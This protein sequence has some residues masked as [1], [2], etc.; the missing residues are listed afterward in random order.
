MLSVAVLCC[1]HL[2]FVTYAFLSLTKAGLFGVAGQESLKDVTLI[3]PLTRAEPEALTPHAYM[4][5]PFPMWGMLLAHVSAIL[6][7]HL[8][9]MLISAVT[10]RLIV[11]HIQY[12]MLAMHG[13]V[14]IVCTAAVF[15]YRGCLLTTGPVYNSLWLVSLFYLLFLPVATGAYYRAFEL[16][17]KYEKAIR[18]KI[19]RDKARKA[20]AAKD[21]SDDDSAPLMRASQ[22][23]SRQ[24]GHG[25]GQ[26]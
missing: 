1:V 16:A 24:R 18:N 3:A 26:V 23:S 6:V 15:S 5:C 20:A 4:R 19:R 2:F 13:V 22:A 9:P 12:P 14:G 25:V 11:P 10:R 8:F 21:D 17:R 7:C